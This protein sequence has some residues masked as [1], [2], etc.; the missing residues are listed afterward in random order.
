ML[1]DPG[2]I[3]ASRIARRR[4]R[5]RPYLRSTTPTTDPHRL[6]R[7][8][9]RG[10]IAWLRT[11]CVRFAASVTADHATLG[12][13]WLATPCRAGPSPAGA[14]HGVSALLHLRPPRPS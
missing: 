2:W 10:S 7:Y 11:P 5:R 9:F 6:G 14:L 3:F 8:A 1:F 12:T 13:G 4:H